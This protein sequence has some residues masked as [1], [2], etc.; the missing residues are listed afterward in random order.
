M[1]VTGA[2]LDTEVRLRVVLPGTRAELSGLLDSSSAGAV[3]QPLHRL[4][5]EG[6]GELLLDVCGLR[7]AD[8]AGLGLVVGVHHRAVLSGRRL[9]LVDVPDRLDSL[10]RHSRLQLVLQRRESGAA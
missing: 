3:R 9:V 10:I 7:V 1:P 6:E 2:S 4:V 8:S 5:D